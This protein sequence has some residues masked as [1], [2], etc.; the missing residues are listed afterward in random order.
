MPSML[1]DMR[2]THYGCSYCSNDDG[3]PAYSIPEVKEAI[4]KLEQELA[5]S[6]KHLL[7]TLIKLEDARAIISSYE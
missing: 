5:L 3:Y 2:K 6:D 7:E 1:D 4:T